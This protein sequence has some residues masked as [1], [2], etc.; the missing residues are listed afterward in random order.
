MNIRSEITK[1]IHKFNSTKPWRCIKAERLII[2]CEDFSDLK[3]ELDNGGSS[4]R[5]HF[6]GKIIFLGLE[7]TVSRRKRYIRI[8]SKNTK[9]HKFSKKYIAS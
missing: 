1:R 5:E 7:I 9:Y 3:L 6:N 2:G 4:L 8:I